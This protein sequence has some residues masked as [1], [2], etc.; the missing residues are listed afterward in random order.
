MRTSTINDKSP[1]SAFK[2]EHVMTKGVRTST[3]NDKRPFS[4]V[5]REHV[6]IVGVRTSTINDQGE[7]TILG[8][9]YIYIYLP[10]FWSKERLLFKNS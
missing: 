6:M 7:I 1:F 10:L 8:D 5:K 2:R 3:I 4:V 9:I